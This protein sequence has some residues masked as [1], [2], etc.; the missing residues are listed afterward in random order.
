MPAKLLKLKKIWK[1][2]RDAADAVANA[3]IP[4]GAQEFLGMV[5][6]ILD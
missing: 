3:L 1:M 4:K 5:W 6:P 2:A